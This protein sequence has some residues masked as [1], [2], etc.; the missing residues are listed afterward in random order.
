M[1]DMGSA[2]RQRGAVVSTQ[3][4]GMH[5]HDLKSPG[6][7]QGQLDT[8]VLLKVCTLFELQNKILAK[9]KSLSHSLFLTNG[10]CPAVR[11][12]S[13]ATNN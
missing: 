11:L 9:F 8:N 10:L 4:T 2:E 12:S 13:F 3:R 6:Q 7:G 1:R 5:I